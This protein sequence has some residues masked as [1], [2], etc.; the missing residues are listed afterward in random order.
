MQVKDHTLQPG[1]NTHDP[2]KGKSE[3]ICILT[4]LDTKAQFEIE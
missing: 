1:I 2:R 4:F 3:I